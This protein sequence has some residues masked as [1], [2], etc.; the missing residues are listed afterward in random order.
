MNTASL[1]LCKELYSLS[2]FVLTE[3]QWYRGRPVYNA[4]YGWDCPAYDLGSLLRKLPRDF[5]LRPIIGA[6]WEIQYAPGISNK[7]RI[8]QADTPEDAAC[9]LVIKLFKQDVIE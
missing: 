9:K 4:P 8:C 5:V 7:E 1:E 6:H 2:G 3:M